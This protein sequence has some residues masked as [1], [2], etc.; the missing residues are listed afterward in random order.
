MLIK[1]GLEIHVQLNTKSKLFC[2]C[3]TAY[4]KAK[5]NENI[6]E[7]CTSQPGAKPMK[8]NSEAI[9]KVLKV[10]KI[11]NAKPKINRPIYFLRKHYFYPDL[12][13]GYQR[14][15]EPIAIDGK[16]ENVT[17]KEI[18]LEEDP[19]RYEI[20]KGYVDYNRS[21][22]PLAEI[23]TNP[24]IKSAEE[25][26][27]ILEK[28][29]KYL[30]YFNILSEEVGSIRID[31]NISL[32]N[33]ARVEIK[34][35]NS[36]E[37]VFN[38]LVFEI[39]RQKNLIDQGQKIYSETRH[40]DEN[41]GITVRLRK[42]ETAEDYRYIPDPDIEAFLISPQEF[43]IIEREINELPEE[44]AKRLVNI[45]QIDYKNAEVICSEKELADAF[46]EVA[47]EKKF[48][49]QKF[50]NWIRGPLKK[51]LNYRNLKFR[52]CGLSARDLEK[53]YELF[54]TNKVS[55]HGLEALLIDVLNLVVEEKSK[56]KEKIEID[57]E[58]IYENSEINKKVD[59]KELIF[60]CEKVIEEN[61]KAVNDYL[62]GNQKS[63]FFL[64]GKVLSKFK[65]EDA[66][67]IAEIIKKIIEEKNKEKAN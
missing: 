10:A 13:S 56:G 50:S 21:G 66:K 18:H 67:K 40:F 42:K 62:N 64:I 47:K 55:D 45:Y 43:E 57:I 9:K 24:E 29:E 19:G 58:K 5:P 63:L 17:I 48:N 16:L 2:E 53:L 15:S 27:R 23:V 11:L 59:E 1:I 60:Y 32:E 36:F 61:I 8:I 44:R 20:K 39:K 38:A 14:T 34:N 26:K 6:C 37:N 65:K 54:A 49:I 7:I 22:V 28:F 25:A 51:Q 41:S 12:P 52:E 46:E 35:I 30:R 31:A 33:M 3:S 4:S